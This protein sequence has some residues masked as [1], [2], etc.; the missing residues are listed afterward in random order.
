MFFLQLRNELWKLFGKKRTYIGTTMFLLAQGIIILILEFAQGPYQ[1]MSRDIE[2]SGHPAEHFMS[3]LTIA[4]LT[5]TP[6]AYFLLPL[7]VALVGGD[8]VAKEA[9][10]GTLRMILCRPISRLRLLLL[11]WIAGG[12]F[13]LALTLSFGL[14]GM[15]FA[16]VFFPSGG[17]FVFLPIDR[18]MSTF[19]GGE[20]W[21]RFA[22]VHV[23]MTM[24][25]VTLMTLAFMFSCFNIKPAAATILA[26][27]FFFISMILHDMP[28]F[29]DMKEWF[30]VH[31]LYVWAHFFRQPVPWWKV[32]ESVS[33]LAGYNLTFLIVGCAVFQARDIKS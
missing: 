9:E 27:S 20:A 11:K 1:Q 14:F 6:I 19:D 29:R 3:N 7:Y 21:G 30:L 31:H 2:N 16:R 13:S 12:I 26:I 4:T 17:L 24:E 33:I 5:L 28:Y 10:D 15:L 25:A 23:V 32:W 18:I 22:V 8:L